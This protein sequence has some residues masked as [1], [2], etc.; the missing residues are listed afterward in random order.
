MD[1]ETL[2]GG[3]QDVRALDVGTGRGA[4]IQS[5]DALLGSYREIVGIDLTDRA[6]ADFEKT[7]QDKPGI[8]FEKMDAGAMSF[9]DGRF[10]LAAITASLHHLDDIDGV[11]SEMK[12]VTRP[13]GLI[14][15]LEMMSDDQTETQMTHVLLHHWW[16]AVDRARGIPHQ[17]T[18]TRQTI[19]DLLDSLGCETLILSDQAQLDTDPLNPETIGFLDNVIDRYLPMAGEQAGADAL[20]SQGE[21]LRVRVHEIGFH[22][23]SMLCWVGRKPS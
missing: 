9:A 23:A 22:G 19:L 17:E 14:L 1:L 2:L 15:V 5:L 11:L 3:M 16:A 10:D 7:F 13:G 6:Q 12:R 18:F 20:I 21:A 4:F 8:R